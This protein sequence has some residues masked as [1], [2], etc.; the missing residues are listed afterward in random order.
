MIKS[1]IYDGMPWVSFNEMGV[2]NFSIVNAHSVVYWQGCLL[3]FLLKSAWSVVY[4][5]GVANFFF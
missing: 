3:F 1:G 2:F 5:L 4:Y